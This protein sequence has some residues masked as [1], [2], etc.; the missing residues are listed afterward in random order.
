[1]NRN[2]DVDPARF[3]V[4]RWTADDGVEIAYVRQGH[5]GVPLLL[6]HGWP[7]SKRLFWRNIQPLADA[8]FD[9]IVPD[10]RGF[11]ESSIPE[12]PETYAD[13]ALS[14]IDAHGLLTSLGIGEC[15]AAGGDFGAGVVQD[16]AARYP[17]FV[18]R[19]IVWNGV[20]PAVDDLYAAAGLPTDQLAEI[21]M[22]SDHLTDN[23]LHADDV[24]AGLGSNQARREHVGGYFT[25]RPWRVGNDPL[26]LSA[27]GA[28]SEDQL[29]FQLEAFGDESRLRATLGYYEGLFHPEFCKTPTLLAEPARDTE[30]LILYG[31]EDQIVHPLLTKRHAVAYPR[32]VGPFLI[33]D[34]GHFVSWEA[35]DVFNSAVICFARD[36]LA[37]RGV[38]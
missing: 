15:V 36:L 29:D 23:G 17:G 38:A 13:I 24:C 8:G 12:S 35:S 26:R 16:L 9:V 25:E 4:L 21:Q 33:E 6:H 3:P 27:P 37:A 2:P 7:G 19:M 28:F 30:T 1:M 14:A 11:G 34:C 5:G 31:V 22:I 32:H 18:K 10:A 20:T